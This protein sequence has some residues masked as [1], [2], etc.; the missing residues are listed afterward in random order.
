L[1]GG[2]GWAWPE[3]TDISGGPG[4]SAPGY[5]ATGHC[6]PTGD[7]PPGEPRPRGDSLSMHLALGFLGVALAAIALVTGLTVAFAAADVGDLVTQQRTNLTEAVAGA[8]GASWAQQSSWDGADLGPTLDLVSRTGVEAEILDQDGSLVTTSANFA[9]LAGMSQVSAPVVFNG[10]RVGTVIVRFSGSGLGSADHPLRSALV[11]A[12]A[13]AAGLAALLALVSGF[14]VARRLTRPVGHIISVTRARGG[15]ERSARIGE[16]RAPSELREMGM[17]LDQMA[18][19]LDRNEQVRRD[20]VADVAHELRTP[21]AV[22]Q[23]GHEALVDGFAEPTPD[24]LASLRDEVLRLARMV[25]DLQSLAAADAAALHLAQRPSDLADIAATAADSL[26]GRFSAAGISLERRLE[27]AEI[28]A[29]PRW[30]HQVV[31]NLLTN[32]LKFS[33]PGGTVSIDTGMAGTEAILHVSDTGIGIPPAELPH[34]FERFWRGRQ[35]SQTSGT[36]IGLAIAAELV[37]AHG[38]NLTAESEP[39]V[40]TRMTMRLPGAHQPARRRGQR[41]RL[42]GPERTAGPTLRQ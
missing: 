4:Y 17:V 9:A 34:I 24:Q 8:A 29:D 28:L 25:D 18:D 3:M 32:A 39:G 37:R 10:Q 15:G 14:V 38:G 16:V 1:A 13:A 23:A 30:M 21:I 41:K 22:L 7:I 35:A 11:R 27:W 36:G 20:L 2:T 19:M 40:G 31:T 26:A 12:V 42:S 6:A 5:T 33:R